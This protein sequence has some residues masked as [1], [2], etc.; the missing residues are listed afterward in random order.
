MVPMVSQ[1]VDSVQVQWSAIGFAGRFPRSILI[2]SIQRFRTVATE[3]FD[4]VGRVFGVVG[5]VTLELM[6][7]VFVAALLNG[8]FQLANLA[9]VGVYGHKTPLT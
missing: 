6:A 5:Q 2:D 1:I 3:L 8:A 7:T 9:F 4:V